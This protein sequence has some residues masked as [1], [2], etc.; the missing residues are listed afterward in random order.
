LKQIKRKG[1][2]G[3]NVFRK[4]VVGVGWECGS[5]CVGKVKSRIAYSNEKEAL[6]FFSS[7]QSF[8][9]PHCAIH[10]VIAFDFIEKH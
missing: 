10:F 4:F 6:I 3:T 2:H 5:W 8:V 1:C 9:A 7:N